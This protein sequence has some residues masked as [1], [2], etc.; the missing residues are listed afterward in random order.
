MAKGLLLGNGI[1]AYL[2]IEDLSI[3]CIGERF[4]MNMVVWQRITRSA[5]IISAR[6]PIRRNSRF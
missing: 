5:F 4:R 3:T 1:N 2:G 6:R